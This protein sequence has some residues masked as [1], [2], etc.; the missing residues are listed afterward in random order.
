[1]HLVNGMRGQAAAA[2]LALLI[3]STVFGGVGYWLGRA[4]GGVG[5]SLD[6]VA[7]LATAQVRAHLMEQVLAAERRELQSHI[8][9]IAGR[10]GEMQADIL[11]LNALGQRLVQMAGLAPDEFDFVNPP[12]LGGI[13]QPASGKTR[14]Q[15]LTRSLLEIEDM[16]ED[17]Q[18][19]LGLLEESI[20]EQDLIDYALPAG[21]PVRSGY[22]SSLYGYRHHPIHRKRSFHSGV[23]FASK[24]GEPVVAVADGV[25]VFAGTRGGYGRVV[26]IRHLDG[27]VT[28]YAHNSRNLVEVGQL[29]ARG[30]VIA[31]VGS[32]GVATGPHVHF[33]VLREGQAIDPME[34][35]ERSPPAAV[36]AIDP[37]SPG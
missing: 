8:D 33:E 19:K 13:D 35:L 5:G 2:F 37:D 26:D 15:D 22:I 27:L 21:W 4:G 25:V 16:L 11:R 24:A 32:S 9:A 28:R 1:M 10:V 23:D 3:V 31:K 30:D 18:R 29:V 6:D 14:I 36:A 12:S 17:R 7:G 20:M 34:Y